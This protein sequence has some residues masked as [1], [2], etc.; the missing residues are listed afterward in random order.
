MIDIAASLLDRALMM[1]AGHSIALCRNIAGT[2]DRSGRGC[3][4]LWNTLELCFCNK[5][6][7][8]SAKPDFQNFQARKNMHT[9]YVYSVTSYCSGYD[10]VCVSASL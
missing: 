2:A 8:N 4:N 10:V 7:A 3:N 9:L 6:S 1:K 5:M